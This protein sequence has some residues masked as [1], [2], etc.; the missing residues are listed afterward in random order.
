[1]TEVKC[2]RCDGE[3]WVADGR[4]DIDCRACGGDGA[5][6]VYDSPGHVKFVQ[7]MAE[8]GIPVKHYH[9]RFYYV[10]P[11][12]F[13]DTEGGLDRQRVYRATTVACREDTLGKQDHIIYP[14]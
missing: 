13:T 14:R 7:D 5:T 9:G 11:A 4:E 8:A 3:G 2:E 1:M 6:Y 12:V 10:G